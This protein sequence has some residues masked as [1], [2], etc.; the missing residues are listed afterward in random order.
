LGAFEHGSLELARAY[1]ALAADGVLPFPLSLKDVTDEK[2]DV[3][4]QRH[5]TIEG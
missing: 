3:L 5:M 2:G 4:E 1:C